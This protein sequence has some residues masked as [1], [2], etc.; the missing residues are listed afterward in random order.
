[1]F[2]LASD[3]DA[4][5][6]ASDTAEGGSDFDDAELP[7]P[8]LGWMQTEFDTLDSFDPAQLNLIILQSALSYQYVKEL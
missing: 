2:V 6:L 4:A 3:H 5:T 8:K 1:M 7:S